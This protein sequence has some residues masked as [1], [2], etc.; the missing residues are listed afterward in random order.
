MRFSERWCSPGW[1]RARHPVVLFCLLASACAVGLGGCGGPA[2]AEARRL[3][4]RIDRPV[5]GHLSEPLLHRVPC[6]DDRARCAGERLG[7]TELRA[8]VR[9]LERLESPRSAE[10]Y[11]LRG[12]LRLALDPSSLE[13]LELAI[14]D[15][16]AAQGLAPGDPRPLADLSALRLHAHDLA[17][18]A[19]DLVAALDTAQRAVELDGA[20]PGGLF[21][22][23]LVA[24]RLGLVEEARSAWE[25]FGSID[26]SA[27]WRRESEERRRRLPRSDAPPPEVRCGGLAP[28]DAWLSSPS[29]SSDLLLLA[30]LDELRGRC[31][32]EL[33]ALAAELSGRGA[34]LPL[35]VLRGLEDGEQ[36]REYREAIRL[37]RLARAPS[38]RSPDAHRWLTA[39]AERPDLH[40]HLKAAGA[41]ELAVRDYAQYRHEEAARRTRE[42]AADADL[43]GPLQRARAAWLL[44]LSEMALFEIESARQSYSRALDL[45][46]EHGDVE[47]MVA[48][49]TLLAGAYDA[50]GDRRAAWS[51]RFQALR[52]TPLVRSFSRAR[53]TWDDA[54]TAAARNYPGLLERLIGE[55]LDQLV[56]REGS[57]ADRAWN[58]YR[59][60]DAAHRY[61][62]RTEAEAQYR[63]AIERA[64][65]LDDDELRQRIEAE[66][67]RG[68]AI[69]RQDRLEELPVSLEP[70]LDYFRSKG[71]IGD[72]A[73]TLVARARAH[74][75]TGR[76][77]KA[78]S[79]LDEALELLA[80]WTEGSPAP[81]D[82]RGFLRAWEELFA[83]RLA[84]S[85]EAGD[86]ET[87]FRWFE[88]ERELLGSGRTVPPAEV[89]ESLARN[90]ALLG[91]RRVE[92]GLWVFLLTR[93]EATQEEIEIAPAELESLVEA[94]RRWDA[95][96]L[97]EARRL[98]LSPFAAT[99]DPVERVFVVGSGALG[100]IPLAAMTDERTGRSM[101]EDA[102]IA[103]LPSAASLVWARRT[104]SAER[105]DG[106]V[107]LVASAAGPGSVWMG[108]PRLPFAEAEVRAAA[109][110][111]RRQPR[112][113][114]DATRGVVVLG[115]GEADPDSI[116]S[117]LGRASIFHFAG[118]AAGAGEA[119]EGYQL[120]VEG[121]TPETAAL[122]LTAERLE[123]PALRLIV[124]SAC[125]DFVHLLDGGLAGVYREL[126]AA[127]V[128][129]L[130]AAVAEVNDHA[131]SEMM[132]R[133]HQE[134]SRGATSGAA[135]RRAQLSLLRSEDRLLSDPRSWGAFVVVG[136][137]EVTVTRP[138]R[139]VSK[140][141]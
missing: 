33:L 28:S 138:Q 1:W 5:L 54:R 135:L 96:A 100:D 37:Y 115:G 7:V 19:S 8:G 58:L 76:V 6:A 107:V 12:L 46:Q 125:G 73:T 131:T 62:R 85:L 89:R 38:T 126:L 86:F 70:V 9:A 36:Q 141:G 63:Q 106:D 114:G 61:G 81:A 108:Y 13:G 57:A 112:P 118:H 48:L 84:L 129:T 127:G 42:L 77:E 132:I 43:A 51:H 82:V 40:P 88:E 133:F 50:L 110:A 75:S 35:I 53:N 116:R 93:H 103:L 87:A 130:I 71:R 3:L 92:D 11:R 101:I 22:L 30:P 119:G 26:A 69:L 102:E 111:W 99:L 134:L 45:Y 139:E 104:A 109:E 117:A 122:L 55:R 41:L 21:Q 10:Q 24:E 17:G 25:R 59:K 124:L 16:Q 98:V 65:A 123:A 137:P 97:A 105:R 52:A 94:G 23:G 56:A 14:A 91:L 83:E 49:H 64:R 31:R 18:D 79:D 29:A 60:A 95:R 120:L 121:A 90:E 20:S 47:G 136:D 44:G 34:T 68:L 72:V 32:A 4:S 67:A 128:P 15:L 66:A 74:R 78:A 39:M 113:S 2:T 140:T 27:E 80:A